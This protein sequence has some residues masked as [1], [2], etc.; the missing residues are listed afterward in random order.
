M[1]GKRD[2]QGLEKEKLALIETNRL[3]DSAMPNKGSQE[4]GRLKI[5]EKIRIISP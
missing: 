2:I 5:V 4:R 3:D 1:G